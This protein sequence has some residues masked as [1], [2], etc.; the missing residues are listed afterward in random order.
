MIQISTQFPLL[1][2]NAKNMNFLGS[3]KLCVKVFIHNVVRFWG[4]LI[5]ISIV[6]IFV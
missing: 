1:I 5:K 2:Q 4:N 6:H 3:N